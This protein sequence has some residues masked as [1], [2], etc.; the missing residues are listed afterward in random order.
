M[1][2][3]SYIWRNIF[4]WCLNITL[5]SKPQKHGG[6]GKERAVMSQWKDGRQEGKEGAKP[7]GLI[8][9]EEQQEMQKKWTETNGKAESGW[10]DVKLEDKDPNNEKTWKEMPPASRPLWQSPGGADHDGLLSQQKLQIRNSPIFK[11]VNTIT[12]DPWEDR[13]SHQPL[14]DTSVQERNL[15]LP[16]GGGCG[17]FISSP[18]NNFLTVSSGMWVGVGSDYSSTGQFTDLI[19]FWRD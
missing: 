12:R 15:N 11:Y 2:Y 18:Q 7:R 8:R 13:H 14:P 5:K 9:L 6:D 16:K 10:E 19:Y 3:T 4:N 17:A 1:E